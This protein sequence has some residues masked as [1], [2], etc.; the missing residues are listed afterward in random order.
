MLF[1][2]SKVL[3][4]VGSVYENSM[5]QKSFFYQNKYDEKFQR[6]IDYITNNYIKFFNSQN[7]VVD[8]E[9]EIKPFMVVNKVFDSYSKK[10]NFPI[11]S[12][13]ELEKYLLL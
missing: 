5:Q 12:I 8:D 9:Y 1:R 2:S 10:I 11:I 3:Q 6:R 7:I 13:F 4:K